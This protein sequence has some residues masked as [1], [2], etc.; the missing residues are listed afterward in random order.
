[1]CML[2]STSDRN[3]LEAIASDRNQPHEYVERALVLL[4]SVERRLD[5]P[6]MPVNP[7]CP[8]IVVRYS[9]SVP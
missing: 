4:A 2:L 6:A 5:L 7:R 8:H 9:S 3:R 1:M